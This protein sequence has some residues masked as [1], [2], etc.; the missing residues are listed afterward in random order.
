MGQ[1]VKFLSAVRERFWRLRD[2]GASSMSYGGIGHTWL[3]TANQNVKDEREVLITFICG[4]AARNWSKHEPESRTRD[5]QRELELLQPGF[6]ASVSKTLFV[7]WLIMPQSGGGY[8][9]PAPGQVT[10]QGPAMHEGLGKLH[11]AGEHT[12][13]QFVGYMEGALR[14][15]VDAAK[16]ILKI[17]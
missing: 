13:Y 10:T 15:G 1:A 7:D 6:Q 17:A 4:P 9:F 16:R 8:S 11:F 2:M 14:S 5:F 3:A 12:C